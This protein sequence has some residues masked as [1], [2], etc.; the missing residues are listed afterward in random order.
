MT[1]QLLGLFPPLAP[2]TAAAEATIA[3]PPSSPSDNLYVTVETF[4]GNRQQ[5]GP[6]RWIP[7]SVLPKRGDTCLVVFDE[8]EA[9]WV[10]LT[11]PIL[12]DVQAA[13]GT[14]TTLAP[15]S[16]ATV[17]VAEPTPNSFVF[18]FGIPRGANG[19]TG[20]QGPTGP[21]G[22][23]G[24]QGPQ[25]P[26]GVVGP[27]LTISGKVTAGSLAIGPA[28]SQIGGGL[29]V[30]G[31]ETVDGGLNVRSGNLTVAAAGSVGGQL[32]VGNLLTSGNV[33][34][35]SLTVGPHDITGSPTTNLTVRDAT[36]NRQLNAANLSC[37]A[38][39]V[40]LG[41]SIGFFGVNPRGPWNSGGGRTGAVACDCLIGLG[42]MF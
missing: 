35:D 20:P 18:S 34:C 8:H 41:G 5:W 14:T 17:S 2:A 13:I 29:T 37:T 21:T 32:Q 42:L 22:P 11:D 40:S 24:P 12:A 25:G 28:S 3:D 23:T 6:C 9:P 4:D 19:A 31:G 16:N 26:P 27:D 1:D 39:S 36:I 10:L 7:G 38:G 30:T 33:N 15:G